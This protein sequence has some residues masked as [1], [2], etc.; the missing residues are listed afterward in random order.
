[1]KEQQTLMFDRS[2]GKLI[3]K[4]VEITKEE[5]ETPSEDEEFSSH[6]SR[7]HNSYYVSTDMISPNGQMI[8][9]IKVRLLAISEIP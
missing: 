6:E 7:G 4:K 8:K 5:D 1:M 3:I 9:D 2:S